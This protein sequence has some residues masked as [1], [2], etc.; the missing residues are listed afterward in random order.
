MDV[1]SSEAKHRNQLPDVG[2]HLLRPLAEVH[3]FELENQ[4]IQ[5]L[6]FGLLR[7]YQRFE[8]LDVKRVEIEQLFA[9]LSLAAHR[10]HTATLSRQFN[11]G[12]KIREHFREEA[13][14]TAML[15]TAV[16]IGLRQSMPSSSIESCARLSETTPLSACGQ[17]NRPRSRRLYLNPECRGFD[18]SHASCAHHAPVSSTQRQAVCLRGRAVQPLWKAAVIAGR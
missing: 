15:G 5:V 1:V 17:T 16:R 6:D 2:V 18:H 14:Y 7:Q 12:M 10:V 8:R 13:S 4:Q 9:A 11:V 3:P